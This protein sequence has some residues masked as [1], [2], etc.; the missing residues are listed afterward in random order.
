MVIQVIIYYGL[1]V[2][3]FCLISFLFCIFMCYTL[4]VTSTKLNTH[5]SKP[6]NS[7]IGQ[8][9]QCPSTS[10]RISKTTLPFGN[11]VVNIF[12]FCAIACFQLSKWPYCGTELAKV[13]INSGFARPQCSRSSKSSNWPCALFTFKCRRIPRKVWKTLFPWVGC[14]WS[15]QRRSPETPNEG[16]LYPSE[17][18]WLAYLSIDG[19]WG[20]LFNVLFSSCNLPNSSFLSSSSSFVLI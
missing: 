19:P 20:H 16:S 9:Y 10:S 18:G 13:H 11:V 17:C 12:Y 15:K 7:F 8:K 4:N 2:D 3:I 5:K 1:K 6:P 14:E